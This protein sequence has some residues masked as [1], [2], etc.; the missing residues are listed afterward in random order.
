[1]LTLRKRV[2]KAFVQKISWKNREAKV[3]PHEER[4]TINHL[5]TNK[6]HIL[7][8]PKNIYEKMY[9]EGDRWIIKCWD[10]SAYSNL[11]VF[12]SFHNVVNDL[13]LMS[14]LSIW[15]NFRHCPGVSIVNFEQIPVVRKIYTRKIDTTLTV[16]KIGAIS[17]LT[18]VMLVLTVMQ[19]RHSL[20]I[21]SVQSFFFTRL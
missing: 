21:R 16:L 8:C 17:V 13:V 7:Q 1:M 19:P 5:P 11:P 2:F 4:G 3:S 18:I 15:I 10:K 6:P 9:H 14:L 12:K 20:E